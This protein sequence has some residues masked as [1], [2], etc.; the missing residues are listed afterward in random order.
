M[1][2]TLIALLVAAVNGEQSFEINGNSR[3][4]Y[5]EWK[6]VIIPKDETKHRG[7]EDSADGSEHALCVADGVGGWSLQG[8]DPGFFS[9]KLTAGCVKHLE[10][11][12]QANARDLNIAGCKGADAEFTGSATIVSV[13]IQD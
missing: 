2:K 7:G 1:Y 11:N 8:I 9:R 4:A 5:F 6:T 12:P 3:G 13:M 10:D